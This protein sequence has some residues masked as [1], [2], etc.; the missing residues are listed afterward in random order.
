MNSSCSIP[1]LLAEVARE[2]GYGQLWNQLTTALD[3]QIAVICEAGSRQRHE[4]P[5]SISEKLAQ[6][7]TTIASCHGQLRLAAK[8]DLMAL[9]LLSHSRAGDVAVT[10]A[11]RFEIAGRLRQMAQQWKATQPDWCE[12]ARLMADSLDTDLQFDLHLDMESEDALAQKVYDLGGVVIPT[13]WKGWPFPRLTVPLPRRRMESVEQ[14]E[15]RWTKEGRSNEGWEQAVMHRLCTSYSQL[16]FWFP[17]VIS[18]DELNLPENRVNDAFPE[19]FTSEDWP[20]IQLQMESRPNVVKRPSI[21][22][23]DATYRAFRC[24]WEEEDFTPEATAKFLGRLTTLRQFFI[25]L[26]EWCQ[27][28]LVQLDTST[29]CGPR[30]WESDERFRHDWEHA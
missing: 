14:I 17:Q 8:N 22:S 28:G 1:V 25:R 3:E 4:L 11:Q 16:S 27:K 5:P 7:K 10:F 23:C 26:Y 21:L 20:V 19:L 30:I 24:H 12:T 13:T 6:A 18:E 9:F 2:V 29:F 15:A